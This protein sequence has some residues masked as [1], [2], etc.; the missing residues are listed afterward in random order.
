MAALRSRICDLGRQARL[1]PRRL[2]RA[3]EGRR[4]R[5]RHA[6]PRVAADDPVRA[7]PRRDRSILASPPRPAQGQ[8]EPRDAACS[9]WRSACASCSAGRW[10]SRRTASATGGRGRRRRHAHAAGVVLLENLRFHPEEEKNDPAFARQ[11]ASLADVYVDDAFGAAH[12]A[13]ASVEG[14]TQYLPRGRGRAADGAGA[15]RTSGTRSSAPDAAVRRDPRRREGVRQD[16][17]HREPARQ[18]GPPAHRRRDGVHVLQGAGPAGRQVARRRRQARRGARASSTDAQQRGVALLLP[19]D[20][21]VADEARGRRA[22]TRCWRSATRGSAIAWGSTSGRRPSPRTRREIADAKTVVWN[23]PMGVFEIDAFA[24][25]TM[26]VAQAVAA[27]GARR[28]S[29]AAIRSPR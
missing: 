3:A 19:V 4:D 22:G 5:R 27:S 1:H 29:A 11:L 28:S 26:A 21:V 2:Q 25:G 7:R 17:R 6:H 20:H 10:P 23:G 16:R 18:G 8:A 15:A 14:I 24:N 12:R 13:H 9:R